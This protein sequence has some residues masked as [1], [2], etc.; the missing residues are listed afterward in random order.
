MVGARVSHYRILDT[1]GSGGMGV[2]YKAED[3]HLGRSVALKFLADHYAHNLSAIQ[4]F[5]GEARAASGLNHPNI[6]VIYAIEE[7]DQ[8]PFIAMELLEGETLR[9]R[10]AKGPLPAGE[11]LDIAVQVARA[12]EAAHSVAI[13]HRDLKPE[14][15]FVTRSGGVKVLDFGLATLA[16]ERPTPDTPLPTTAATQLCLTKPGEAVGTVA[17]M[18][19][20]Q[21]LGEKV[22]G[23]ADLFAFGLVLYEMA[24]GMLPFMGTTYPALVDA[25]LHQEPV[26]LSARRSALPRGLDA[27]V[28]KCL[29][30]KREQ[31]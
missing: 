22:D 5:K 24:A 17:Y 31:R 2:V 11:L 30:K 13:V 25:L 6:C 7:Y 21:M 4:R 15:I 27:V 18:S 16:A 29:H 19:P 9:A 10:L 26:P 23:R 28:S 8:K 1:L 14:N 20:E 3:L 12:L